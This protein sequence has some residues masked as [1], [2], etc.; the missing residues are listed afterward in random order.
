MYEIC[1]LL[2]LWADDLIDRRQPVLVSDSERVLRIT[3]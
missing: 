2:A 1:M 3:G